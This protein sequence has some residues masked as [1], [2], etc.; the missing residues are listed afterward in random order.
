[1]VILLFPLSTVCTHEN[2]MSVR[3]KYSAGQKLSASLNFP[4][5]SSAAHY[6]HSE[7]RSKHPCHLCLILAL[8]WPT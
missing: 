2:K 3:K 4:S 1:M 8:I 6:P 7:T 5:H